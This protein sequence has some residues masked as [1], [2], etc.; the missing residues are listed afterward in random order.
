VQYSVSRREATC[1][2]LSAYYKMSSDEITI[3]TEILN[4]IFHL[5]CD[6]PI[7]LHDL[8]NDSHFHEF[9]WAV[10]QV[11]RHWRGAF[12][13]Y[14]NLWTS[15]ALKPG[16]FNAAY[17]VEMNRRAA[18]YLERSREQPLTIVVFAPCSGTQEFPKTVW[19][20]LLSCLKRWKRPIWCCGMELRGTNS[21]DGEGTHRVSSPSRCLYPIPRP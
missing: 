9:P 17:F 8:K 19:R 14:T 5:L 2:E 15:F 3:P 12:V 4:D 1:R 21:A 13:S 7:A 16:N 11:C 20:M 6:G 10:G 18:M